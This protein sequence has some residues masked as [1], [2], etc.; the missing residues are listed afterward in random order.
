[1]AF[2]INSNTSN[3]IQVKNKSNTIN[4]IAGQRTM[5]SILL[6]V[7]EG[8]TPVLS[9][10]FSSHATTITSDC[11]IINGTV[12]FYFDAKAPNTPETF[13]AQTIYVKTSVM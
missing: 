2:G 9:T 13:T 8:Y 5:S 11:R 12:M 4:V 10:V 7:V 1:M 3:I 6:D